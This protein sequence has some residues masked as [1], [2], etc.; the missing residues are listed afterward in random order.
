MT[1]AIA[2]IAVRTAY[3]FWPARSACN[4]RDTDTAVVI[5]P[6]SAAP[7]EREVG[8]PAISTDVASADRSCSEPT[9]LT[10]NPCAAG[11]HSRAGTWR[12]RIGAGAG[13]EAG[14]NRCGS[15]VDRWDQ[16]KA[17]VRRVAL[18]VARH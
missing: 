14:R 8:V 11:A 18:P 16:G 1:S 5:D 6:R 10:V 3:H 7:R 15:A 4:T 13:G 12:W 2:S 9:R 17:P